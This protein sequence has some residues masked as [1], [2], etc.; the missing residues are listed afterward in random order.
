MHNRAYA[1]KAIVAIVALTLIQTIG[2]MVVAVVSMVSSSVD[3]SRPVL[4]LLVTLSLVSLFDC[5]ITLA[6]LRPLNLIQFKL[7]QSERSIDNLSNLNLTLREQR[8]DYLNHLQVVYSLIEMDEYGDAKEYMERLYS[9]I[10]KVGNYLKTSLPT[11][12]AILQAKAQMCQTRAIQ[13][14]ISVTSSLKDIAI[15]AWELCRILGNLI[16]NSINAL[17]QVDDNRE[18]FLKIELFEDIRHHG[19]RICNNGPEIPKD[20]MNRIFEPGFTTH[21]ESG[22]GMGLYITKRLIEGCKGR[23][24]VSSKSDSTCFEGIIPRSM[25]IEP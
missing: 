25:K 9:D 18:K 19:F 8:H 6:A 20:H 14:D 21:S 5:L 7:Y 11:V 1:Q 13:C 17:G 3:L 16:D 15:P 2:V 23:I 22:D 12:N 24:L 10:Q 4:V